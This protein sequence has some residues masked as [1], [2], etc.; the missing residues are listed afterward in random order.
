MGFEQ[1]DASACVFRHHDRAICTAVYGDDFTTEGPKAELDWFVAELR[2]KFELVESARLG[3][4]EED[5]K[6]GRILNRVVRWTAA[7]LEYEAG[8]R[9]A[10]HFL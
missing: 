4:A 2:G 8:P 10:T 3:P 9:Q 7:G 1:G 5:D 6:E